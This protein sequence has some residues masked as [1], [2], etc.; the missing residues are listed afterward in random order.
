[1][2]GSSLFD[3]QCGCVPTESKIKP[4]SGLYIV[5]SRANAVAYIIKLCRHPNRV[6]GDRLKPLY[7]VVTDSC[8]KK[9]W[10]PLAKGPGISDNAGAYEGVTHYSTVPIENES[11]P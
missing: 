3:K 8:L 7:G 4:Y 6:H 11:A 5:L 9:L 2:N 1:M 10:V